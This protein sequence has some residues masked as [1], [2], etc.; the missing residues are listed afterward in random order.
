VIA[1]NRRSLPIGTRVATAALFVVF[2]TAVAVAACGGGGTG[3][4][5]SSVA[6]TQPAAT[7]PGPETEAPRGVA[8]PAAVAKTRTAILEAARQP[9]YG[10]LAEQLDPETFSYSFGE[11]GDPVAYWQRLE[12]D[13]HVPVV[14]KLLPR[15]LSTQ[16]AKQRG[17]Y[18][19]PAA[20]AKPPSAWAARDRAD[21][22]LLYSQSDVR[23]FEQFGSCI[24]YRV[25]IRKDGTWLF[26]VA[27]D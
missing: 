6:T 4:G 27:G 17:I 8:L 23:R 20:Y 18:V 3:G 15:V 9:D 26:Y 7:S 19:W 11:Q 24:G 22:R 1:L 2:C 10:S 25:G 13:E 14:S 5:P 16:A 21:M 12:V